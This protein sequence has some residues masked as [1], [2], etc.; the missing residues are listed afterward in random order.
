MAAVG[1]AA[2]GL[3]VYLLRTP[4]DEKKARKDEESKPLLKSVRSEVI[5]DAEA[6]F[7]MVSLD[8]RGESR[9]M[10]LEEDVSSEDDDSD[11]ET[12]AP[13]TPRTI[14]L[15]LDKVGAAIDAETN[16]REFEMISPRLEAFLEDGKSPRGK[17]PRV[18]K[19][20]MSTSGGRGRAAPARGSPGF[21]K[22]TQRAPIPKFDLD[23][24]DDL[25]DSDE[26]M[27]LEEAK[28]IIQRQRA[29]IRAEETAEKFAIVSP[30]LDKFL[31]EK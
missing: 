14:K 13:V 29:S 27:D 9:T 31:Q 4:N 11:E 23:D 26:A 5:G 19:A 28:E 20:P 10:S 8:E 1:V 3:A 17:S 30:R 6:D 15:T 16:A 7:V 12:V 24:F 22:R 2:V 25:S 18:V 21:A